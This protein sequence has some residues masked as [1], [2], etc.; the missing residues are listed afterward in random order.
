MNKTFSISLVFITVDLN[1][2]LFKC[3][4]NA[5]CLLANKN[6]VFETIV[7]FS[8]G[9]PKDYNSL[10]AITYSK[11]DK[12][13]ASFSRN[14]AVKIV[15]APNIAFLDNDTIVSKKW[16]DRLVT[17]TQ[18]EYID[19]VFFQELDEQSQ[20]FAPELSVIPPIYFADTAACLI[21]RLVFEKKLYFDESMSRGE[22]ADFAT[23][24]IRYQFL[25]EFS[26]IT[27][28]DHEH[29][30][31]LIKNLKTWITRPYYMKL[32]KRF[33]LG[34]DQ[35]VE[36]L[37][38][39]SYLNIM[40]DNNKMSQR[41]KNDFFIYDDSLFYTKDKKLFKKKKFHIYLKSKDVKVF[42]VD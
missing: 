8:S 4:E 19:A 12:T 23:K 20:P 36:T 39:K 22:D 27:F 11:V 41:I 28:K 2:T 13:N 32:V 35:K 15:R 21:K 3:I 42:E 18:Q 34:Y 33:A 30:N 31:I 24:L 9:N 17:F 10:Y 40:I 5:Q 7:I 6:K 26:K 37:K 14:S 16:I 29:Q 1:A 25:V 38:I